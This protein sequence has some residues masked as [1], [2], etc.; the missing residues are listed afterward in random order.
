MIA[1]LAKER[2][3]YVISD[4][5]Y[6]EF[7]YDGLKATSIMEIEGYRKRMQFL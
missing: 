1:S 4:E 2:G 7:V 6:R 3:L 5:V